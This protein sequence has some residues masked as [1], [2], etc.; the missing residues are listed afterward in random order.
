M[1]KRKVTKENIIYLLLFLL[2]YIIYILLYIQ[3]TVPVNN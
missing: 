1:F 2:L 3:Y